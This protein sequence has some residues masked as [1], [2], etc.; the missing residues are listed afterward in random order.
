[1][2]EYHFF[3]APVAIGA[4]KHA[5]PPDVRLQLELK[6]EQRF[7]NGVAYLHYVQQP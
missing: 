3:V 5:L 4:G 6:E 1:V 2:D 7:S